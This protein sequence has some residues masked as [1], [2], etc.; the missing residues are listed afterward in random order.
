MV[1]KKGFSGRLNLRGIFV[2]A[3]LARGA[4]GSPLRVENGHGEMKL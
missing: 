3:T 1:Q 2:R 4:N